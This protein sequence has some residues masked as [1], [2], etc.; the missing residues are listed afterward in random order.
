[1]QRLLGAAGTSSM[2]W[3]V[4]G[5]FNAEP[6]ATRDDLQHHG[7]QAAVIALLDGE[8]TYVGGRGALSNLGHYMAH[9]SLGPALGMPTVVQ[10]PLSPHAPVAALLH[11]VA[12]DMWVNVFRQPMP[13][14]R[15]IV[16]P[17][18]L[19]PCLVAATQAAAALVTEAERTVRDAGV[20]VAPPGARWRSHL[21][22]VMTST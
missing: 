15:R 9:P 3:L 7:R 20:D 22:Y 16:G 18:G 11:G 5:D 14:R 4:G 6:Q 1:M 21:I 2:P 19:E 10:V 8:A 17:L 12:Q 13:M